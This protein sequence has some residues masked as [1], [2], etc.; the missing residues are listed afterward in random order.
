[1]WKEYSRSY[2]KN[3]RSSGISVMVAAFISALFLSLLCSLFY[4]LWKYEVERI[5]IEEGSWQGRIEGSFDEDTL[6]A[7]QNFPNIEKV[8]INQEGTEGEK[9]AVDLYFEDMGTILED[10][11]KIAKLA[12]VPPEAVSCHHSLLAMYLIRDPQDTAPRLIFPLFLAITAMA[13]ISLVMIIH[14]SF[15]V[16]MNARVHQFG[17]F[18]SI[19]ATP[20]QIRTCLLQE[21]AALCAVPVVSGNLLGIMIAMGLLKLANIM[22]GNLAEGRHEAEWGYHPLVFICTFAVT[23]FTVWL[24]AW[25]PARK[26]SRLT[27]LEAIKNTGELPLYKRKNSRV[28]S[29]FFGLE[30]ELAS[31]ALKAQ[32]KAWRTATLS[33]TFSFMAFTL[34]QCFFTLTDISTRMTYFEKYQDVW[35]V[36]VT[37][38]DTEMDTFGGTKQM[39]ELLDVRSCTVYQKAEAK[40][41]IT[42]EEISGQ[43]RA[44]G[45]FENADQT[46]VSDTDSGWMIHAP[47]VIL[48]DASFLSYCEQIGA[49]PRLD[50]AVILNRIRDSRNPNFRDPDYIP[51]LKEDR[52]ITVLRSTADDK[53]AAKIPVITYTQEVPV[54]REEYG[55]LDYYELVHFLPV[56]L[57]KQIKTPIGGAEE[58]F[59]IR[60]LA[61]ENAAMDELDRLEKEVTRLVGSGYTIVSENRI[62]EK[63]SD[64]KMKDGMMLIFGGFCVLLAFIGIGNVFSNTLGFVR[65]RRREFARY[66]SVG[67]TPGGI[68]KMFCVEALIIAGR[69]VL[70]TL[71]L[72]ILLAALMLKAS[73]LEPMIFIRE[74]PFI[75]VL[76]FIIAVFAF[77]ALA[78]YIGGKKVLRYKL[79]DIL[80]DDT[81]N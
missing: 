80:R 62:Q 32:K 48:D 40:R 19:G 26:L 59:Y 13:C 75:P 61:G 12:E 41:L 76:A 18:S 2:I 29:F 1:M 66:I 81:M 70:V 30:G 71:P 63:L 49:E 43:F 52:G 74:A 20:G 14:N 55:T 35:D 68:K 15:A 36:M 47:V 11:P 10:L 58:D 21:A 45:G 17:I 22:A 44:A 28:L 65:Q 39:Q 57:W 51:Y 27:P 31:N 34:M 7:V 8:V 78:Y 56:S 73:Y 60:V 24:S 69:P 23:V 79:A 50:G 6:A 46:F 33:L 4:N 16:T 64:D 42:E 53:M 67:L 77:V 72:T 38:K 3:N 9:A 5:Q 37:V 54:L 25:Y